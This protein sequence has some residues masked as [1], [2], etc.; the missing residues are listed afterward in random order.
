MAFDDDFEI[1]N[2][3]QINELEIQNEI[4]I[5]NEVRRVMKQE[6]P[7]ALSE[8]QFIGTYRL[9]K[10]LVQKLMD[11]LSPFMSSPSTITGLS[12]QRKLLTALR[13]FA[14]GSY[15]QDIG[16]H[17]GAAVSQASVSRCITEVANALN[18]PEILNKYIHFPSTIDE[19]KEVRLGFYEKF[20][21]PGVVGVIDGTHIAIVPPK[22]DEP[23]YPEHVY[24]NRK[25]YHGIN[26]QLVFGH[27]K[28]DNII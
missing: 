27:L 12:I 26:T 20:G 6:D 11:E 13:F 9:S 14:S 17:R 23:I 24:I 28:H 8:Q 19:L 18:V 5:T 16:E 21:I 10:V 7:F 3:M 15:Q 1:Y 4:N 22:S 25:G 2:I